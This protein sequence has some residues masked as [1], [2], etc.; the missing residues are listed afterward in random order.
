MKVT[1]CEAHQFPNDDIV[2]IDYTQ[3]CNSSFNTKNINY[4]SYFLILFLSCG[5]FIFSN[6]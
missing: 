6:F 5:V 4:F 3:I 1:C 2:A